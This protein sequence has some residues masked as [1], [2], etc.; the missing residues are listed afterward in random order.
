MKGERWLRMAA[1]VSALGFEGS[2]RRVKALG[3]GVNGSGFRV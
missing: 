3:F 1:M 2:C